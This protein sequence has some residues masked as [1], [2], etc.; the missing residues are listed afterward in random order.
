MT[1]LQAEWHR[2]YRP[3]PISTLSAGTDAGDDDTCLITPQGLVRAMVLEL[4]R[5]A[6]WATLAALWQGV[7]LDLALP[8]PAIAVSGVDGYQLWFSLAE[9]LPA[10]QAH[11]FLEALR[12][13]YLPEV[14][15]TR[16]SLWPDL[17]A[18][19]VSAIPG[20]QVQTEQWAAFLAPDLAPMFAQTPWLDMPPSPEG[21][22]E[23]LSRLHSIQPAELQAA[24]AQLQAAHALPS[25]A[26]PSV[27]ASASTCG[28][29]HAS[30]PCQDPKR[31]L[32]RIMNDD[33]VPLAMR[34]EAAK[35]LL[36]Y[37]TRA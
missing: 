24:L 14:A 17:Q 12:A 20:Q 31:F 8:A 33:T 22:A 21:Q 3:N 13:R 7:Q 35:A 1:R 15:P 16:L 28:D 26:S 23:L 18:R 2:L 37:T 29:A 30:E 34:I 36:P 10:P 32:L 9:P 11:A 25:S 27:S 4:A 5:P 6:H 19:Q